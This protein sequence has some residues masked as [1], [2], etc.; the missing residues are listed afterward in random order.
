MIDRGQRWRQKRSGRIVVI[1]SPEVHGTGPSWYY[2]DDPA[3]EWHHC[4]VADFFVWREYELI[5][6][7]PLEE[8]VPMTFAGSFPPD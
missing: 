2:E 1:L 4:D 7:E 5:Q 6:P 3:K 8:G